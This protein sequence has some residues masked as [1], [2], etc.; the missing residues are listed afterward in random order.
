MFDIK[1]LDVSCFQPHGESFYID[2]KLSSNQKIF[3]YT[4]ISNLLMLLGYRDG[5]GKLYITQRNNFSDRR[6][7]GEFYDRKNHFYRF[8]VVNEKP[9]EQTLNSWK[10]RDKQIKESCE[11]Y[12]SCWTCKEEEDFLMWKAYG[13][14]DFGI[15]IGTTIEKVVQSVDFSTFNIYC[16]KMRYGKE[17]PI[18]E[19][20][21]AMFYKTNYYKGEEEL[22]FYLIEKEQDKE[23][24]NSMLFT[25]SP[26]I[27]IEEVILSPF[28][29]I[30]MV[31]IT[32]EF[33]LQKYS[34][35]KDK[36]IA[37]KIMEYQK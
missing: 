3:K 36:I 28:A 34:Y 30:E 31:E 18:Y 37:S 7:K 27:M 4:T 20:I 22:R 1:S 25:V 5:K 12:T 8:N 21:D 17:K 24:R 35:L 16:S 32:Q 19:V 6:E 2:K 33:L 10:Y 9:S 23:R 14:T 26:Q 11:L 13:G 29:K 15:R